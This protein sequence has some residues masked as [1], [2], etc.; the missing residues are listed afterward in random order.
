MSDDEELNELLAN[1]DKKTE[2]RSQRV[3][4]TKP[5]VEVAEDE[6]KESLGRGSACQWSKQS[7]S[8][9]VPS[10]TTSKNLMPGLYEIDSNPQMGLFFNRIG[11]GTEGLVRFKDSASEEVINEINLFWDREDLF[12]RFG[13]MFKRGILLYGPPG[14]GKTCTIKQVIEGLIQRQGVVFKFGSPDLFSKGL[15]VFREIEPDTPCIILQE[16]LD[17]ILETYNESK[18]INILDGVDLI[19]KVVFL[20]TTNYPERLGARIVNRPSRFDKRIRIKHP[21]DEARMTYFNHLFDS[22]KDLRDKFDLNEWVRNTENMS[23]AHL[24]ELFVGVVILGQ[25]FSD[26]VTRLKSMKETLADKD[27]SN[28]GFV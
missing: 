4:E 26:V 18:V 20:A 9:F 16:D 3:R 14:S 24:K 12:R 5:S 28:V 25:T 21:N 11:M 8:I 15:Q 2:I 23:I 10:S 13:L 7:E 1:V 17:S 22:K 6:S 27:D 19:D